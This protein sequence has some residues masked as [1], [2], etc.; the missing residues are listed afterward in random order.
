MV[1]GLINRGGSILNKIN[2]FDRDSND[3]A[4]AGPAGVGK[5]CKICDRKFMTLKTFR[6]HKSNLASL[7]QEVLE[8]ESQTQQKE[9]E[10]RQLRDTMKQLKTEIDERKLAVKDDKQ[11]IERHISQLSVENHRL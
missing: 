9:S 6:T 7:E 8:N 10:F 4:K 1:T 11:K 3:S 2:I 5:C